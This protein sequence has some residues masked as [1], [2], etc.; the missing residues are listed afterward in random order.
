MKTLKLNV[1]KFIKV[2]NLTFLF[3]LLFSFFFISCDDDKTNINDQAR[4]TIKL[5]DA[6]GDFDAVYID[7]QDVLINREDSNNE[8]DSGWVS[9]GQVNAGV[10]NLLE[11]TGGVNVILADTEIPA[12]RINQ[13]RLVLGDEN[14]I[15][16]NGE[17]FPLTTPSAQES[18][19]KLNVHQE[20]QAGIEYSFVIDFDVDKS[21]ITETSSGKFILSPVL[22]I[23]TEAT[24]G[25][26]TGT[27]LPKDIQATASITVGED[28]ITAYTNEDGVFMLYGIPEGIYDVVITPDAESGYTQTTVTNVSVEVGKTT[29]IGEINLE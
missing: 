14:S 19:L 20:L 7:V 5:T 29:D 4:V 10:Y 9:V 2:L 6:P 8:D 24:T 18:G 26:V 15:V 17:E 23:S 27:V 16:V 12:G 1:M 22:R 21:I 3:T 28:S 13:I 25:I 11:L